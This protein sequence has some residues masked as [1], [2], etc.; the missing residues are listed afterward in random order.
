MQAWY[1]RLRIFI[2]QLFHG[3][4][5]TAGPGISVVSSTTGYTL[6]STSSAQAYTLA[7]D[8]ST[9]ADINPVSLTDLTFDFEAN[10]TY[11]FRF[12]GNVSPNTATTG[13]GFQLL[14]T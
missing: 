10:S 8:E 5:I 4:N 11:A 12:V 6:S 3:E 2:N 9:T 13:C 1:N 7:A 14:I